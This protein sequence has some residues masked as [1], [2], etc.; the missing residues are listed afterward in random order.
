MKLKIEKGIPI[1]HSDIL[2]DALMKMEV[3]DSIFFE[4]IKTSVLRQ[5][6]KKAYAK[7]AGRTLEFAFKQQD[8]PF[9]SRFWITKIVN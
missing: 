5:R 6:V 2:V 7:V 1:S 8:E 4:G 9:G 3:G